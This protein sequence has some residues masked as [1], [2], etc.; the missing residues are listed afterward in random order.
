L[1]I[2]VTAWRSNLC[3]VDWRVFA[4]VL[5]ES[6]TSEFMGTKGVGETLSERAQ[7]YVKL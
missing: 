7:C 2:I 4:D 6:N 1:L 3:R 5:A